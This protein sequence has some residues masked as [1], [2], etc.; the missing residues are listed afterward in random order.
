MRYESWISSRYLTSAKGGFLF[1]LHSVSVG[2]IAVG[3]MALI[4]VIGIME[5]F[6]NNLRDKI[7]GSTPHILIEK[8]TG[9]REYQGLISDIEQIEGVKGSSVYF[10][11]NIF[12]EYGGRAMGLVVRGI[13]PATEP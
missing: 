8:E 1:F 11:G 2:G 10:Q 5:G 7:I 13:D 12:L 9:I 4:V 3:V 6:G